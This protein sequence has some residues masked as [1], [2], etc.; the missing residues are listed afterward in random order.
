MTRPSAFMVE[1]IASVGFGG[2]VDEFFARAVGYTPSVRSLMEQSHWFKELKQIQSSQKHEDQRDERR[3]YS[4]GKNSR[5]HLG[6][7]MDIDCHCHVY[8][9]SG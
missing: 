7:Q 1:L 6:L 3:F 9:E 2:S 4:Q 5:R 8:D